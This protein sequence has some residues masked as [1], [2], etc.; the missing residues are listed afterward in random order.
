MLGFGPHAAG[1]VASLCGRACKSP[2]VR[3]FSRALLAACSVALLTVGLASPAFAQAPP[4]IILNPASQNLAVGS[5]VSFFADADGVPVPTVQWQV[6][7]NGGATFTNIGGAT[8]TVLSFTVTAG[9]NGNEYRAVFTNSLGSATTTAALLMALTPNSI[10][11]SGGN[12]QSTPVNSVFA[13]PLQ[14]TVRDSSNIPV[15][16][17]TVTFTAPAS[18]ASATFSG[19]NTISAITNGSG[20]ASVS[21]TAN[22]TVGSYAVNATVAGVVTPASFNLTNTAISS[23][24]LTSSLNPSNFGQSVTFT[25]TVT[26]VSPT[27]TVTFKDGGTVLGTGTLN[28]NGQATFTTSSLSVGSHS[29]TAAYG[30]DANNVASTSAVLTQLVTQLVNIPADSIRLRALQVA[31]TNIEAQSSGAAFSGAVDD[32]IAD[33][34]SE[35]GG[36]LMS[37]RSNGVRINFG[38]DD[39]ATKPRTRVASQYDAETAARTF[40]FR[41]SGRSTIDQNA[42]LPP[43][44]RSF[45]PDPSMSS[46]RVDDSFTALGYA[47][48]PVTKSAPL[49]I[50]AP[51][52]WQLWADVRGAG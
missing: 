36:T 40:A 2:V 31:V 33:G 11:V 18:G 29:I 42:G 10:T 45:V 21:A 34:F 39:D 51:K 16:G 6:S 7:T 3:I 9:Q 38:A 46:N 32:A 28:A 17:V 30:G 4:H 8:S 44:V 12:N 27:G 20:V 19:I 47:N 48:P 14:A 25:A 37:P 5:P 1:R 15:P 13:S 35:G 26:G 50:V 22:A 49:L 43:S 23:V 24:T 41:D 52:V